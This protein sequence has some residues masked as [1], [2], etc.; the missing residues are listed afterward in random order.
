MKGWLIVNSFVK[1]DKFSEIYNL[2]LEAGKKVG[3]ELDLKTSSDIFCSV[4]SGFEGMELPDFVIFW[5]KDILLARRLEQAGLRLF[6]PSES[7]E[8][9]DDKGQTA[10]ALQ[11]KGIRTPLTFLSPKA[12]PSFGCTD[13][14]HAICA[15]GIKIRKAQ[16][17][18]VVDLNLM[19]RPGIQ[20]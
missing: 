2:L 13:L 17:P 12:Y 20:R 4:Q 14:F 16:K 9:C 6:N 18:S 10:I 19:R 11:A 5:D 1:W 15:V 8:V 3:V 7:I